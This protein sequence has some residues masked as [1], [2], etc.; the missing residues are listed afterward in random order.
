MKTS[1]S[2]V[3]RISGAACSPHRHLQVAP[4]IFLLLLALAPLAMAQQV[5]RWKAP[6]E[7]ESVIAWR[8]EAPAA[9]ARPLPFSAPWMT[10]N[11]GLIST[12][13]SPIALATG[14]A[15]GDGDID[16]VAARAYA[17]GG[18]VYLRNDRKG[19]LAQ[20]VSYAGTGKASGIVMADLDND[21]DLDVAV[22]DS[23]GTATGNTVSV[24]LGNG[25][26]TF[27][28]RQ[29]WSVG[30]GT[31]VPLGIAAADFDADGD[32]DLAVAA[33]GYV[34]GGSTAVLLF[35][36]GNAIFAAPVTFPATAS[37]SDIAAGDVNG[38]GR[39]DL[40]IA[41]ELYTVS[42]LLNNGAGGFGPAVLYKNLGGN[43]AG[44]LF[45]TI[46]LGDLDKDG[47]LD[48]VYGNTRTWDDTAITGRAVQLRN[49]GTGAFTR[50]ADI[51]FQFYSSGPTD[52]ALADLNGDGAADLLAT[53][54]T[55]RVND[56]VW[57]VL[58]NGTGG[59]GP[60]A[61]YPGGQATIAL[62]AA[63]MNGDN[64]A[65]ILTA[66]SYSNA[67]TVRFNP[68]TGFFPILPSYFVGYLQGFQDAAD[69]DGDGDL[70]LFTTGPN[71]IQGG[72][73]I[74][75]N[76]GAGG[77]LQHTVLSNGVDGLT[78]GVLRDLNGDGK[79]DLLF[80]NANTSSQYDFFTALNNGDGTFGAIKRSVV[81]SA[82]W[83][84]ID[85]FDLDN[86]GDLDVVDMENLGAPGIPNGRFFIALNNGDGTFQTPYSY[87]LP[88][89]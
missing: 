2:L 79:V 28:A 37:P 8:A 34:G 86:D 4:N 42:V 63:D 16:V 57:V 82:G 25:N 29:P 32:V 45:P 20:P 15:D 74:L 83:G 69:V 56:G 35:N 49:N 54:Y 58:N 21:G 3:S 41:H 6:I 23:D 78:A 52:V 61:L 48:I 10:Y 53:S 77:F 12:A 80:N 85:A 33:H 9:K 81:R 73:F 19:S 7:A 11:T 64:V 70:D 67:V 66:D 13:G 38:D 62:A 26:G 39:P 55:A 46:A 18:F 36:N 51:P 50:G 17:E 5:D 30:S 59:F 40:V 27:G 89:P 43:N 87:D 72:G 76:S 60:A 47:D 65:D 75:Y 71:Y 68:G 88:A 14:D 1:S 24:Y 44:P 31:V 22:T 84:Q